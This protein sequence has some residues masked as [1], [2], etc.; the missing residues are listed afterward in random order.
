LRKRNLYKPA[1][2]GKFNI[3]EGDDHAG[4]QIRP[5]RAAPPLSA[6]VTPRPC[7]VHVPL[8]A[9]HYNRLINKRSA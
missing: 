7:L 2:M 8:A 3:G 4:A 5:H 9:I 1:D 6:Q